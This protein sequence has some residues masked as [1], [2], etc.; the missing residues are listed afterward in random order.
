MRLLLAQ[1]T[2]L[3]VKDDVLCRWKTGVNQARTL[4]I[5]IPTAMRRDIMYFVHGHRTSG[6]FGK[7]RSMER[8][9]RRYYWPGMSSDLLR[10]INTCP[11]CCMNNPGPGLGKLPLSQELFGV[12]FARIAVDIIT[13]FKET[14]DG[15]TCMM[16][17]TDYYTKYTK[18]FPLRDHK[19]ATCARA[20]VRGWVLF[21]GAPLMMHSD[22][23][24]EFESDL[25]ARNVSLSGY[26]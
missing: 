11:T 26:L 2:E 22:Q 7:K 20:F 25:M 19:A 21:L 14:P 8:L 18:I 15:N 10:W 6:H 13:G 4:Q 5:I 23:G 16:V 12:R 24:R 9:S 1:W 17:V 3:E